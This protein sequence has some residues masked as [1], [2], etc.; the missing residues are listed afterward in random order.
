MKPILNSKQIKSKLT[1]EDVIKLFCELQG[2]TTVLYDSQGHPIFNTSICH[3]GDSNK[4]YY[5]PETGV[6]HCYTCGKSTDIF[7]IVQDALGLDFSEALEYVTNYFKLNTNGFYKEEEEIIDDWDIFNKI[8]D[9]K[10]PTIN[11]EDIE[12][13]PE[14]LL[15]YFFPLAAPTEWQKDGIS[16]EVMRHYG[17]RID[18][19]LEKIVIGHRDINGKLVGIRGRS[20]NQ[21]E[22]DE[23]KKY[24]PIFIEGDVYNH[25]L[26]K[27]LY[28]LYENKETIKKIKKACI[29]EAEK[30]VM[31]IASMYGINECFAVAACGSNVSK[32]QAS[33]LLNLGVT[34]IILAFDADHIGQKGD[35]EV[36][37]YEAKLRKIMEPFLPYVNVSIMFDYEHLLPH[38]ASPSDCGKEIFEKLYHSRVKISSYN[39]KIKKWR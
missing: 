11:I 33:L 21:K 29:F 9:Y 27:N 19:A 24:M 20:F 25:P 14:N 35:P 12:P 26:G 37:A 10:E 32:E 4:L 38:K 3:G 15:E 22:I 28:G 7:G 8:Q 31:Q 2:D 23:G 16:P 30:S 18:S 5:Y 1:T 36:T 13:I 17:I 6:V 34:E 39:E